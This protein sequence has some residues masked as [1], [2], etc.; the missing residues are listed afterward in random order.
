MREPYP[1]H[2]LSCGADTPATEPRSPGE[3]QE[4]PV[5]DQAS[6]GSVRSVWMGRAPERYDWAHEPEHVHMHVRGEIG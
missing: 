1:V 4:C 5:L 6:L 2:T 3:E